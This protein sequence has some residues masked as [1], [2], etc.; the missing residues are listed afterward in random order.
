VKNGIEVLGSNTKS[1]KANWNNHL[2]LA[3]ED[4]KQEWM[5]REKGPK[6]WGHYQIDSYFVECIIQGKKPTITVEDA[7]KAQKVAAK[8]RHSST[9]T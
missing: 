8:I 6:V 4:T 7:I 5:F 2:V 1:L 3:G 9:H